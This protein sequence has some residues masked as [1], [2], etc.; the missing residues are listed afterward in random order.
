VAGGGY[1]LY[2]TKNDTAPSPV[3]SST[4]TNN[5]NYLVQLTPGW[6]TDVG[7][8]ASS[9][10]AYGTFD[11]GGNVSQWIETINVFNGT[12][13]YRGLRGGFAGGRLDYIKSSFRDGAAPGYTG[14]FDGFRVLYVPEPST[15]ALLG[16]GAFGLLAWAWRRRK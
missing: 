10:S 13:V 3:L 5:A 15:L 14:G 4:G 1:W 2:S 11:Q 9:P 6:L 16:M 12:D 7:A 8:F